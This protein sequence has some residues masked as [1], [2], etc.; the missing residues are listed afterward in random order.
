MLEFQ[1]GAF[2]SVRMTP[3]RVCEICGRVPPTEEGFWDL[4]SECHQVYISFLGWLRHNPDLNVN[5][6]QAL[7]IDPGEK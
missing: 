2:V 3:D 1:P 5:D 7:T 6:I 4:C